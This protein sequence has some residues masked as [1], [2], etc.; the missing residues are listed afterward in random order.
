[1]CYF[2]SANIL[3]LSTRFLNKERWFTIRREKKIQ[4]K[5]HINLALVNKQVTGISVTNSFNCT[6]LIH[7]A[8]SALG[9]YQTKPKGEK[10]Y[11]TECLV[12][13]LINPI[14]ELHSSLMTTDHAFDV[15][16]PGGLR[17]MTLKGLIF[18]TCCWPQS[19]HFWQVSYQENVA[20]DLCG[21]GTLQ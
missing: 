1:M 7:L 6:F 14:L 21:S 2:N 10:C 18:S 11:F 19:K 15:M 20:P 8:G 17:G 12:M 13:Y 4:E 3:H 16:T 9:N 5:R